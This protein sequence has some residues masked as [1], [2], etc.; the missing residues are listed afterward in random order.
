[1]DK[2][3]VQAIIALIDAQL[4]HLTRKHSAKNMNE[5]DYIASSYSLTHLRIRLESYV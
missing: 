4:L 1:M 2:L 5:N 3:T